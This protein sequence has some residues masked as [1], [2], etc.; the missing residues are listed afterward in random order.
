MEFLKS[1]TSL[2]QSALIF[3]FASLILSIPFI[4]RR[5][6]LGLN[7]D[8]FSCIMC[9]NCCR[10]AFIVLTDED[11]S[12]ISQ[13]GYKDFAV[14]T[15]SGEKKL[16]RVK[17]RC[18]FVKSDKCSIYEVRPRACRKFPFQKLFS[19]IPYLRDWSCCPA[20]KKLKEDVK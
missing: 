19:R 1:F 5:I 8:K 10:F 16:K 12:R 15:P 18:V 20:I 4:V 17:G 7:K 3:A 9:G 2:Y 6:V 11:I 14:E 13:A